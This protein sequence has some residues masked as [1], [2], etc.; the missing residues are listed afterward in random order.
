[1]AHKGPGKA[2]ISPFFQE[3]DVYKALCLTFDASCTMDLVKRAQNVL[4][5]NV[6]AE[7]VGLMTVHLK[8]HKSD[9]IKLRT[10][11]Q[12]V[13]KNMKKH[14]A[15]YRDETKAKED[16]LNLLPS[17]LASRVRGALKLK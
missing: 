2:L 16:P 12:A 14:V 4:E 8:N 6:S 7:T 9:K 15:K 1:M 13:I 3:L 5:I 17:V 10:A 11:M